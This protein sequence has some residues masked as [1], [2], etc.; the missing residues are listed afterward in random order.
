MWWQDIG[1]F[2]EKIY[3]W[4]NRQMLGEELEVEV[5]SCLWEAGMIGSPLGS[6]PLYKATGLNIADLH[7]ID[8]PEQTIFTS[9]IFLVY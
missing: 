6:E 8:F 1:H 2:G 7:P 5:R 9:L 4:I 3:I